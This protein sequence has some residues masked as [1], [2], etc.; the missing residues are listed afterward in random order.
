VTPK[1][2]SQLIFLEID[3]VS[4]FYAH[5]ADLVKSYRF[6]YQVEALFINFSVSTFKKAV[7]DE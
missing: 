5:S 6:V 3:T 4:P 7:L 2:G 1:L